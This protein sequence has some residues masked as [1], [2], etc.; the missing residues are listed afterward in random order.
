MAITIDN[1]ATLGGSRGDRYVKGMGF[2]LVSLRV[3]PADYSATGLLMAPLLKP[4]GWG[5]VLGVIGQCWATSPTG[6]PPT[7][8]QKPFVIVWDTLNN[9]IRAY[10]GSA[11]ALAEIAAGDIAANDV[12]RVILVGG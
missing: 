6:S 7:W 9:S 4:L 11:G 8:T 2:K 3:Q 12:V 1:S 10:K 5:K